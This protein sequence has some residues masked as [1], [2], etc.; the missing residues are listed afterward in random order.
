MLGFE[1]FLRLDV[2]QWDA[3]INDL[4]LIITLIASLGIELDSLSEE[5]LKEINNKILTCSKDLSF[6][7]IND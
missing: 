3:V 1:L 7:I 5:D 2:S 6:I 4:I